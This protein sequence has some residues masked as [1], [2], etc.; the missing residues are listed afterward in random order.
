M[1]SHQLI[2]L[3]ICATYLIAITVFGIWI[4]RKES[5]TQEGYFLGGRKFGWFS[6]GCSV[7]ATN[8]SI[9]QFMSV[10]GMSRDIGLASINNDLVGGLLMAISALFFVPIYIR[11]RLFTM[12]EFLARRY[13]PAARQVFGWVYLVQSVLQQ[14]TG[15]YI[16]GLALLGMFGF[17]NEHLPLACLIIGL[18][19]GLYS[20]LGGLTAVVKTDVVQLGLLL[21]GGMLLS[22][23]AVDRAGGWSALHAQ[24]GTTHFELL[25]P[26][27]TAMPWTALPGIALHS[28]YFAFCSIH[29]LQRVLGAQNEYHARQGMLF[30]AWLKFLAIPL[31]ALPGIA[32]VVLLP[33]ATGDATYAALARE[34]LPVGLSGLVLAGMLAALMSSADSSVN[35]VACVVAADIYPSIAKKPTEATGLR[36]GKWT[37]AALVVFAVVVAPHYQ[38]LGTIYPFILRLG[39]FLLL[40]VGLCFLFGR[41]STRVNAQGAIACLGIGSLLGL[42]YVVATSLPATKASLPG[43]LTA[44]HFYEML[45]LFFVFNTAVLFGVSWLTPPP[46]PDRLAVLTER[47]AGVDTGAEGRPLWQSFNLWLA[48]FCGTLGLIYL[49]F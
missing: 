33:Q 12:P 7:F 45:P 48:L 1:T 19:V 14:P 11:S 17:G 25:L 28:C 23:M 24:L 26:R 27:G 49:V 35:A 29:I 37:G 47:V 22:Y 16:G 32:A 6:I 46:P 20:V 2:D 39:G 15:Y 5:G 42:A 3:G 38:N 36:I 40:P 18:T 43:W 41:F 4:G 8:I 30:A 34:I 9:T 31:F 21:V 13:G 44:L 10:S